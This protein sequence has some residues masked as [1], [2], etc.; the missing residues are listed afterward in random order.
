[1]SGI[2]K[3]FPGV[4]AL[5]AMQLEVLPGEVHA[6]VGENGAGKST[7]M[8]ILAGVY[9]PDA[10]RIEFAG[11]SDVRIADEQAAQKLGIAIVYQER[12]LFDALSVAENIFAGRQPVRLG[13]WIDSGAMASR[14]RQLLQKV[15]LDVH[16]NAPLS[17]LSPA[18][19][20]LVEIAKA[21][22]LDARLIIFDEPTAA[23]TEG[24]TKTLFAVI[25]SLQK[26]GTAVIYISHRLEEIFAI[27]NRVTVLKDGR[28]QGTLPIAEATPANLVRRMVGRELAN[29]SRATPI[30]NKNQGK[31]PALEVR[32][33]SDATSRHQKRT[34]L[35]NISFEVHSDEVVVLAGLAGA[36]RTETALS[37][38]GARPFRTGNLLLNGRAAHIRSVPQAIAAGI[39]YLPEDRKQAGLFL[40]MS[41]AHNMAAASLKQFGSIISSEAAIGRTAKEYCQRLGIACHSTDQSVRSLSGGNQQKV[42]LAKWL[43]VGP[44]VLIVDEPT[45]GVDVGAKAQVHRL[46]FDLAERGTAVLVISSDLPEVLTLGDRV[47]VMAQGRIAGQL[48]RAD[49]TEERIVHLASGMAATAHSS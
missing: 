46:L 39:G 5:D 32:G 44:R 3:D 6:V 27:A 48:S 1:M 45:R 30:N 13:N 12:S 14:A 18:E 42:L 35:A 24:E 37:I 34:T 36:G 29:L 8:H 41:I 9:Q 7:L 23:L 17:S 33:L 26:A 49:A 10:G 38:F 15:G 11:H 22:S 28:W 19:Q 47:I 4:R 2:C 43:L 16:P 21:L 31:A 40:E 25:C 20:Q